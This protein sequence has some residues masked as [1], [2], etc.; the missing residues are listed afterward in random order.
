MHTDGVRGVGLAFSRRFWLF[1]AV[2][3]GPRH[4]VRRPRAG[5]RATVGKRI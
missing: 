2:R 3:A 4:T 5:A 1:G